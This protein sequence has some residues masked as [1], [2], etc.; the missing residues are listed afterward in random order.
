[1]DQSLSPV[2]QERPDLYPS[3]AVTRAMVRKA[4]LTENKSDVDLTDS[5]IGQSLTNEITKFLSQSLPENQTDSNEK[6]S[7][8]DHFF[9]PLV[10]EDRDIRSR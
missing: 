2:E 7:V 5:F 6:F 10:E 1:M 9:V 4:M 3:C 8:S